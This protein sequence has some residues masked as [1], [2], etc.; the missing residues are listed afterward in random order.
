[1]INELTFYKYLFCKKAVYPPVTNC[2]YEKYDITKSLGKRYYV[3]RVFK[4][5]K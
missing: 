3:L 4:F 5:S 2:A 1:M